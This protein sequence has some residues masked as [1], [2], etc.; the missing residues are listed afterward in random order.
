DNKLLGRARVKRRDGAAIRDVALQASGQLCLRMYGPSARPELPKVL[1]ENSFSWDPDERPVDRN[2]RSV[3]VIARRNLKYPLFAAFDEPDR[4]NSCPRRAATI[5]AP[6][7]LAR[8]NG[9]FMMDQARAMGGRLLTAH[10][11]D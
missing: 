6:Q 1:M 10:G 3:Y 8:L 4:I 5:T 7:A 2:R 9:G 11:A